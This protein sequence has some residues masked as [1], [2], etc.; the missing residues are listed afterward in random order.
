M[1]DRSAEPWYATAAYLYVLHLD[2]GIRRWPG[3]TCAAIQTIGT[4]GCAVV[5]NRILP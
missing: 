4:T 3:S 5:A 2:N 1:A